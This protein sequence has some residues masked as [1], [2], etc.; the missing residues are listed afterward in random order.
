VF[1][2][3]LLLLLLLVTEYTTGMVHLKNIE[4]MNV[5]PGGTYSDASALKGESYTEIRPMEAA[6]IHADTRTD[7]QT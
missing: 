6:M 3:L 2:L 4:F 1:D 5:I 7:G